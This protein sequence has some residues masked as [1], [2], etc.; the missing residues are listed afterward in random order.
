MSTSQ[1]EAE[2]L[3]AAIAGEHAALYGVGVAGGKLSGARFRAATTLYEQHRKRR[4]LLADLLVQSG[5]TPAA[6]E[7][8]YDLPQVV[9][10]PATAVALV[11]G[12][13][14]RLGAVYAD[15]VEAAEQDGPRTFAVQALIA[16]AREQLAWGGRPEAFPG[17]T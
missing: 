13:E 10:D 8:A 17:Q 5:Q 4:D 11:L 3:Q 12:I 1:T 15:L 9:T 14:R 16:T 6:A 2:A 7:P